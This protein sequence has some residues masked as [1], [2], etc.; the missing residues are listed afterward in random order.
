VLN[1][2]PVLPVTETGLGA[3]LSDQ[4]RRLG[5]AGFPLVVFRG[6]P[7]AEEVQWQELERSLKAS[8]ENGGWPAV[9]VQG[10]PELALRAIRAG[11]APWGLQLGQAGSVRAFPELAAL[12]LGT[13]FRG[14]GN[15]DAIESGFD[16]AGVEAGDGSW[17]TLARGCSILEGKGI[18]PVAFGA[19]T[20][21]DAQDCYRA[22]AE[23][24]T[25]GAAVLSA[26]GP[27]DLL[28][29]AQRRRWRFR[30]PFQRGQG[31][32]LIGGSGCGKSTLA[33]LLG[34]RLH[35]PV[36]DLDEAVVRR[37][38]KPIS[39]IFAE[40][41]EQAFRTMETEA[42]CEAFRSAA[43]LALG[44]GA[45]ESEAIRNAALESGFA[46]LWIA[47]D[48]G[49]I[50]RRVAQDPVRPLSQEREAFL[51]RWSVRT[52][53]WMEAP[54]LLPLGRAPWQLVDALSGSGD[55]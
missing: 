30:P 13:A 34:A 40:D 43:V 54:V 21:E 49:R 52:P 18:A 25:M 23:A 7:L 9:H 24:L 31:V 6:E 44:G 22:G 12:R 53:K 16:L 36:R 29:E 38:R 42:T 35:L 3:R 28:W 50:W 19:L 48:P 37:A 4:V 17:E 45:W 27:S 47:D 10:V 55:S 14:V 5:E 46:V 15:L 39:R 41:G 11:L 33:R 51:A 2:P 1:L 32:A 8:K 26:S 20:L